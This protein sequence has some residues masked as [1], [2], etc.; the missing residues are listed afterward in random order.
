MSIYSIPLYTKDGELC[1]VG[2]TRQVMVG[3]YEAGSKNWS[4]VSDRLK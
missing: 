2:P 4:A 3:R 1:G